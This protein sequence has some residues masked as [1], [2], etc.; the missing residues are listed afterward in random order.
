MQ[1]YSLVGNLL[2]LKGVSVMSQDTSPEQTSTDP[3]ETPIMQRVFNSIWF[4]AG[5]AIL[6]FVL[7]Y[8]VWGFIDLLTI[9]L[10]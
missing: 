10:G 5:L 1:G 7:S 4:L 3:S 8:I 6:F 9:P 2:D